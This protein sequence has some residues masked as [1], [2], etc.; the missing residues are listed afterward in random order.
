MRGWRPPVN[1]RGARRGAAWNESSTTDIASFFGLANVQ[2]Y[3]RIR[4][5]R[6]RHETPAPARRR[7]ASVPNTSRENTM[8]IQLTKDILGKTSGERIDVADA[9]ADT[10]VRQGWA[11]PI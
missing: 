10:L 9:D 4:H 11:Q 3:T 1:G 7:S 8:F 2:T 5:A 6:P